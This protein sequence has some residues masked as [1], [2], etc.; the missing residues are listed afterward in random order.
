MTE[1]E[2]RSYPRFERRDILIKLLDPLDR[3]IDDKTVLADISQGGAGLTTRAR[4][5]PGE[6]IKFHVLLP[7]GKLATGLGKVRWVAEQNP[8]FSRQI[9]IEFMD[10]GWGGFGR[11]QEALGGGSDLSPAGEAG[12]LDAMLMGACAMVG[13]LI[14]RASAP[15]PAVLDG[16]LSVVAIGVVAF[17]A[18]LLKR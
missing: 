3:V 2:R 5:L 16:T 10:F 6:S 9:G 11:L 18:T 17:L 8:S 13:F 14:F 12:F 7:N 15:H 1:Q 4:V